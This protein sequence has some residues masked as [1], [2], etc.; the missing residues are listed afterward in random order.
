[1]VGPGVEFNSCKGKATFPESTALPLQY[2]NVY[3]N[4]LNGRQG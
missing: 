3:G 1:M 2:Q 4:I